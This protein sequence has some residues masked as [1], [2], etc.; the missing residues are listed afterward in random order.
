MHVCVCV[1]IES[2]STVL[3]RCGVLHTVSTESVWIT[4]PEVSPGRWRQS[5][6]WFI[7]VRS[8]AYCFGFVACS[9]CFSAISPLIQ[10]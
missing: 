4:E 2:A 5:H 6:L 1:C 7:Q 9:L 3:W 8:T 10:L